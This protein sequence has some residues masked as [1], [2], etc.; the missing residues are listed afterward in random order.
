MEAF[1]T[2]KVFATL[3]GKHDETLVIWLNSQ[4]I[5]LTFEHLL[6]QSTPPSRS[7]ALLHVGE[8]ELH[9]FLALQPNCNLVIILF[10]FKVIANTRKDV[11]HLLANMSHSVNLAYFVM[12]VVLSIWVEKAVRVS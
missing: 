6:K 7:Y 4:P 11:I 2:L 1:K 10:P 3:C 9:L 5:H 8:N 12:E